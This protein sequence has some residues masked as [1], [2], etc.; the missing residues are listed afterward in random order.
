MG[1]PILL[2]DTVKRV[3]QHRVKY[4]DTGQIDGNGDR[5]AKLRP[6]ARNL[7]RRFRPDVFVHFPDL[8]VALKQRNKIIRGDH[9]QLRM[10]P[11]DKRLRADQPRL[12][13]SDIIF[14]LIVH[15]KLIAVQS[16]A[17]IIEQTLIEQ[18]ALT[19]LIVEH[20][21]ML[22][23]VAARDIARGARHIKH[24]YGFQ[25]GLPWHHA[26][27]QAYTRV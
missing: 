5:H 10:V 1:Q 8:S 12:F 7:P 4:I 23:K 14:G 15:F 26:H 13:F 6:P 25:I 27:A 21:Q 11:A 17:Q 16:A 20:D 19:Y 3:L 9:P 2:K 18:F 24:L 22:L